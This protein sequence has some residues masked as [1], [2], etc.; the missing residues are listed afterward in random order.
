MRLSEFF[1]ASKKSTVSFRLDKTSNEQEEKTLSGRPRLQ[2]KHLCNFSSDRSANAWLLC[3]ASF[4]FQRTTKNH[5]IFWTFVD[6]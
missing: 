3:G 5:T 4:I 6:L 2:P 1:S